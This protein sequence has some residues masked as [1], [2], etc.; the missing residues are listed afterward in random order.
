MKHKNNKT[1]IS[2]ATNTKTKKNNKT[3]RHTFGFNANLTKYCPC[4]KQCS[5]VCLNSSSLTI[6]SPFLKQLSIKSNSLYQCETSIAVPK[7]RTK[8][9]N[10]STVSDLDE[11]VTP[12]R[13][14]SNSLSLQLISY[15]QIFTNTKQPK[16]QRT[17]KRV[18]K[19]K[20]RQ[21]SIFGSPLTSNCKQTGSSAISAPSINTKYPK[22]KPKTNFKTTI[23]TKNSC[24]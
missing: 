22:P 8:S 3:F 21:T 10:V 2:R 6:F 16:H 15:Y 7:I 14:D 24:M 19:E 11:I 1:H 5:I 23:Q 13:T 4:S 12:L 9:S 20:K 18:R 17:N